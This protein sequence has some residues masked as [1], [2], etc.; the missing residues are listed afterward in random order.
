MENDRYGGGSVMVWGGVP[1]DGRTDLHV[2]DR[3]TMTAQRYRD[4]FLPFLDPI[5]RPFAGTVGEGFIVMHD[6]ARPHIAR[7]RSA[8]LDQQGTEVMG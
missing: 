5:M 7:I 2:L 4:E 1:I 3:G 8:Y 6:D